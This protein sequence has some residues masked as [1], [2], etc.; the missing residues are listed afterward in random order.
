LSGEVN[1]ILIILKPIAYLWSGQAARRKALL[2]RGNQCLE[3]IKINMTKI[4][5]CREECM[6]MVAQ[7]DHQFILL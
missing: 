5:N 7:E 6:G 4:I 2:G 1:V 3:L